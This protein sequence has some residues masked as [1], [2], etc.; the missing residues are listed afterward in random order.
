M[1]IA[2]LPDTISCRMNRDYMEK[3]ALLGK[4]VAKPLLNKILGGAALGA[5]FGELG[6][7]AT[8]EGYE[9]QTAGQI[10]GRILFNAG[11][12]GAGAR[13]GG[14]AF[15]TA[16]TGIPIKDLALNVQSSGLVNKLKEEAEANIAASEAAS[17]KSNLE[18]WLWGG[19]GL[20]AL[21]LGGLAL[22]KY[23]NKKDPVAAADRAKLR[24]RLAGDDALP[25]R[26]AEV[27]IPIESP[28]MTDKMLENLDSGM[29][30]Q[31][32]KTI[33]LNS[34]KKDPTTGKLIS[35]D[36]WTDKY[37]EHGEFL[38]D[39]YKTD[40]TMIDLEKASSYMADRA[41][42]AGYTWCV[43]TKCA[44]QLPPPEDSAAGQPPPPAPQQSTP[45]NQATQQVSPEAEGKTHAPQRSSRTSSIDKI[46]H[47]V[48]GVHSTLAH[49]SNKESIRLSAQANASAARQPWDDLKN[50]I[51]A[52][53][54]Q[55]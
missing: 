23:W 45:G 53:G 40:E 39:K 7:L 20:G 28:E 38:P 6:M 21:G 44:E 46:E 43:M 15:T 18:K 55:Q 14:A 25:G 27:E 41:R 17:K 5:G 13:M 52:M 51:A 16:I 48:H 11:L 35:Y 34:R 33:K 29:R 50:R 19:L 42:V 22:Y 49:M 36:A 24:Y 1:T 37:G 8:G 12:G 10:G 3:R 47:A 9:G 26:E 54:G 4:F 31:L 2:L 32:R 30:R